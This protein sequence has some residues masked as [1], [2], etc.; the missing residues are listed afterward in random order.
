MQSNP[1][2]GIRENIFLWNLEFWAF[3]TGTH[4]EAFEIA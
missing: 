3:E 2:P 1:D 4:L